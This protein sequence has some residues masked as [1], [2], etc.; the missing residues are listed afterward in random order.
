MA[1]NLDSI[2]SSLRER[3][4][5]VV[6]LGTPKVGK[7]TIASESPNP[8]FIPIKGEEG[9][10]EIDVQSFPIAENY[11]DII[12]AI[13][14]LYKEQHDYKTVVIDSISTCEPIIWD[15]TCSINGT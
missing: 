2:N 7:S 9:I 1:F 15:H 11:D 13:G 8:V 5:R 10:D 14:T 6:V 3:P 4:K 12:S